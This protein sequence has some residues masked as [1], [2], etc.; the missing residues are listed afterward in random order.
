MAEARR[1]RTLDPSSLLVRTNLTLA[2]S[3]LL[4]VLL[5]IVVLNFFVIAPIAERSAD[6]EAALLVLSAQT[7]VE[8]P[9]AAR[10]YFE[11]ELAQNHDLI[12]SADPQERPPSDLDEPYLDVLV[13]K[14]SARLDQP[15]VLAASDDLVWADVPMGDTLLQVGFAPD[16]RGIQPLWVV[17]VI[18]ALGGAIV[19]VTSLFIVSR[20]TRPLV[21]VAKRAESF[22]GMGDIEPLPE[23]GPRELVALAR[24]FNTMAEEIANLMANRTTLL[25]GVSHDLR[26]PLTR[27]RLAVELLPDSVPEDLV[28]R[29]ERNLAAMEALIADALQFARGT[30]EQPGPA[31]VAHA[32]RDL[33]QQ[34]SP[35]VPFAVENPDRVPG[36]VAI[37]ALNRVIQNLIENGRQHGRGVQVVL[38]GASVHVADHGPGIPEH[39]RRAVLQPF[40]RLDE[41]RAAAT[42]GSGLGLAIVRQLCDAHGWR[43]ELADNPA[44]P[45]H[46]NGAPAAPGVEN[47][48]G[49]RVTVRLDGR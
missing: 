36:T 16:R 45:P 7:W 43:V 22:R 39:E 13:E 37:G 49:L 40:F 24:N 5:A 29:F 23:R 25:A 27:M 19:F 18:M 26:T 44:M 15:V 41:S 30:A 14:L 10:P 2:I 33:C 42:G 4:I 1:R 47:G 11:L 32:L 9:P 46:P 12:I 35:P 17:V 21:D 34:F 8:L 20:L 31:D 6:D 3:A 28:Q 38:D 48:P